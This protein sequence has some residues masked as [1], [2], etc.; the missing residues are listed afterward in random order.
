VQESHII[1]TL[2]I[3][4]TP[5]LGCEC[6]LWGVAEVASTAW[7]RAVSSFDETYPIGSDLGDL[8]LVKSE[9]STEAALEEIR[10]LVLESE[11]P[12]GRTAGVAVATP[13]DHSSE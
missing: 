5:Y 11:A 1:I 3:L 7:N 6:A 4:C 2:P 13:K 12:K 9:K 10:D 8:L